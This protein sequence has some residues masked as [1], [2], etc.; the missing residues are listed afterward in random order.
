MCGEG[1]G[2]GG[3]KLFVFVHAYCLNAII[4]IRRVHGWTQTDV[5]GGEGV[6]QPMDMVMVEG[7]P[8]DHVHKVHKL[9][10]YTKQ[11]LA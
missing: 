9:L 8:V 3:K 11:C 7:G 6:H 4:Y 5:V 2:G 10:S 1:G